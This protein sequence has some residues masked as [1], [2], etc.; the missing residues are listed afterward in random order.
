[1]G[2]KKNKNKP[3]Y[4]QNFPI[5]TFFFFFLALLFVLPENHLTLR[6]TVNLGNYHLG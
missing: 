2:K 3:P 6:S 4:T 1:M 5:F